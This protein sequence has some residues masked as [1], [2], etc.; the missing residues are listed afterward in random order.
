LLTALVGVMFSAAV[1][2]ETAFAADWFEQ[3]KRKCEF[4]SP[5]FAVL[6]PS[7][8]RKQIANGEWQY[9]RVPAS[10]IRQLRDKPDGSSLYT[11]EALSPVQVTS[12]KAAIEKWKGGAQGAAMALFLAQ[13]PGAAGF[14]GL[15]QGQL[16]SY[17]GSDAGASTYS[18]DRFNDFVTSGGRIGYQLAFRTPRGPDKP[19][20]FV[21]STYEVQVGAEPSPRR[22]SVL[23]CLLPVEILFTEVETKNA[24][25]NANNKKYIRQPNGGWRRW[26]IDTQKYESLIL[27]YTEQDELFANFVDAQDVKTAYRVSLNG[28][29]LQTRTAGQNNWLNLYIATELK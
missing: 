14:W 7:L 12:L 29:A 17:L 21:N 5:A 25:P 4:E 8:E 16:M 15:V 18:W 11:T 24:G 3:E 6:K 13:L 10:V 2:A 1:M 26:D 19:L 28:G 23:A 27:A 9:F 20:I 22:W